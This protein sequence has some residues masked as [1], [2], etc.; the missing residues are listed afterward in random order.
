MA[1]PAAALEKAGSE[2]R[3][4]KGRL[5][6]K[7]ESPAIG[8]DDRGVQ[9]LELLLHQRN[10]KRLSQQINLKRFVGTFWGLTAENLP[11]IGCHEECR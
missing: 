9:R 3:F 8:D 7:R 4:A 1:S 6:Q 5:S 10:R 2:R 11:A